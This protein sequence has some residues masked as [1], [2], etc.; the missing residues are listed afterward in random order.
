MFRIK[1][2]L[3]VVGTI[4]ISNLI[5][6]SCVYADQLAARRLKHAAGNWYNNQG[7]LV[8]SIHDDYI[9]ECKADSTDFA[10]GGGGTASSFFMVREAKGYRLMYL[11]WE[12]SYNGPQSDPESR[13]FRAFLIV[14]GGG[15][16]F[17]K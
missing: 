1:N 14:D 2:I 15:K 9:N 3:L 6:S 13:Y 10:A 16:L 7:K 5:L 8:L 4:M 11:N 12:T 17:R